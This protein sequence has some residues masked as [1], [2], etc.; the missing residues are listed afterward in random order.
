ML[1]ADGEL[2]LRLL[3]LSMF[4]TEFRALLPG[5]GDRLLEAFAR[6][7]GGAADRAPS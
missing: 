3:P 6:L 4:S 1:D 5:D 7:A 2:L